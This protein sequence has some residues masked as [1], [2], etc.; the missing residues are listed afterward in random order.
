M[1]IQ[2]NHPKG[3][4][5]RVERHAAAVCAMKVMSI[6]NAAWAGQGVL[7]LSHTRAG[8]RS[9]SWVWRATVFDKYA[10]HAAASLLLS[11]GEV[12]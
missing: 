10:A 3:S 11:D 5:R 9:I 12:S 6:R 1:R 7:S 8:T 2:H 4:I